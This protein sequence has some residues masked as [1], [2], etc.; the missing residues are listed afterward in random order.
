MSDTALGQIFAEIDERLAPAAIDGLKSYERMPS[1]DPAKFPALVV[2]DDGDD[3]AEQE[4]GSTRLG[5]M[6]SV[7]GY[8]EGQ[9]GAATHD[10]MLQLHA[11]VVA[12]LCDDGG[13]LGGLV[14]N[15][16][17][18]GRRRVVVAQLANKRRIG[19]AQ[20]F[21]ITFATERGNPAKFA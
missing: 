15:I 17:I 16:E 3:L 8:M 21:E 2:Y 10:A 9:G 4:T 12:A 18:A 20:D 14:E 19:F 11:A 13:N 6:V 5:L 7:E 1:G